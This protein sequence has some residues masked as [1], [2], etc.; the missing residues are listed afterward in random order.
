MTRIRLALLSLVSLVGCQNFDWST[1][2]QVHLPA[3]HK[4]IDMTQE[5]NV[6]VIQATDR[7]GKHYSVRR[8]ESDRTT[9]LDG[10]ERLVPKK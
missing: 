8:P 1:F 4:L 7:N 10:L 9:A 5:N 2:T 6:Y 3:G